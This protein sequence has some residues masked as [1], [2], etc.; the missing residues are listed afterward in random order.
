MRIASVT[1]VFLA[2]GV[3]LVAGVSRRAPAL[4]QDVAGGR[5]IG[6]MSDLMAKVIYPASDAVFYIETRTPKTETEW[7]ELQGKTLILAESAN[8]LMMPGR[9][10][11]QDRWIADTRLMLEA[12]TE[13]FKAAKQ[14]D[15]AGLI[16]VNEALYNSCV[17]CHRHYRPN[18]GRGRAGGPGTPSGRE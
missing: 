15:V 16:A 10:R 4:G 1:A 6:T 2:G 3:S 14:H 13:A 17:T 7:D 12:G 18:Y 8:L 5:Q 11:D 9:A